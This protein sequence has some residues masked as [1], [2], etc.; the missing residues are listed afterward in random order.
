LGT[1]TVRGEQVLVVVDRDLLQL[2]RAAD[3]M[4]LDEVR[5]H[6]GTFRLVTGPSDGDPIA[7][8]SAV[9]RPPDVFR[10][11]ELAV[12]PSPVLG[13][14]GGFAAALDGP[15][16]VAGSLAE[17]QSGWRT[18][19]S[20]DLSGDPLGPDIIGPP[21]TSVAIATWPAVYIA[22]T[23]GTVSLTDVESG[24]DLC[25]A[26]QLPTDARSIATADNGDL[27]V[28]LGTDLARFKPPI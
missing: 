21:I 24:H 14:S 7:V 10:L 28:G 22:R 26:L 15:Y 9:D 3:G 16:L 4:L 8:I 13:L 17:R 5:K 25:P 11:E 23:D 1:A 6:R 20:C 12:P 27:L 18:V 2:R 19:W